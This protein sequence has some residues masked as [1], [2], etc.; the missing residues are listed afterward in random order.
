MFLRKTGRQCGKIRKVNSHFAEANY[1]PVFVLFGVSV[2]PHNSFLTDRG[3]GE[4]TI[5]FDALQFSIAK[6]GLRRQPR[7]ILLRT[8][9]HCQFSHLISFSRIPKRTLGTSNRNVNWPKENDASLLTRK[10]YAGLP[11]SGSTRGP[12]GPGSPTPP[13]SFFS[14]IMQ[15][16]GNLR[17]TPYFEQILGSGPPSGVKTLLAPWQKSWIRP[18]CPEFSCVVW[19]LGTKDLGC[20]ILMWIYI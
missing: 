18:W 12:G 5:Y 14:K 15:F 9:L 19:N 4:L 8:V 3:D 20:L 11:T 10:C 7:F 1:R 6:R 2:T 16:S 17:E 13:P